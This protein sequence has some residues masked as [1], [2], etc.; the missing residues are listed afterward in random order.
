MPSSDS[1]TRYVAAVTE[2]LGE[3]SITLVDDVLDRYGEHTLPAPDTR[4]GAVAY[5]DSTAAV[6]TLV[7][8]ANEHGVA[9]FP[10]SNG[11][12]IGLGTRSPV[13][14]GQVVVD[15]GRRMNRI[16][17]IDETLGYCVLEPGVSFRAL[18]D[19]LLERGSRLMMS[20]TAGPSQGSVLANALD[21]G[22][23]SGAY[24]DHFGMSCGV[25]VVLGNGDVIR[26]GDGSLAG[27]AHPNWHV[28]KYS[29]GPFLDGLFSQSNFGIV[30][31]MGMWLM[32]R[33]PHIEPFFFTFPDDDDLGEVIELIRPLKQSNFVPTLIRATNDLYLLSSATS[34]PEYARTGGTRTLSDAGRAALRER[35]GL[36]AWTVSGAFYGASKAAVAPSVE[37]VVRHFTAS[38]KGRHISLDEAQEIAPLHIAINA[39]TGVPTDSELKM[40]GWRPGG[41]VAW[42]S[43]GTPMVGSVAAEFQRAARRICTDHGLEYLLSNVCGP[44]FA[45]GVH[46][47]LFNRENADECARADACYR[48]MA[49]LFASN[50]VF[51]GR[52]PTLYQSFH[53]EQRMP[54][55]NAACAAIKHAL[56]PNGVIAPGKYGIE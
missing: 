35:Y 20:P 49:T 44:R 40:L 48:Q 27:D 18:H 22:G 33:P 28:S 15:L 17:E 9:L 12:N 50:G 45:R 43:A 47:I 42:L 53:A 10:I 34:N 1:I 8:L 52:A 38:G 19:T 3:A 41:G 26:T 21:K 5:P 14:P 30:T 31:R 11:Q 13:R 55:F 25:E 7:R 56:D 6:Q 36:G 4:P 24:A 16:L 37:R 32:P 46:S 2:L 54:E 39:N 29:F 51:V 23:G